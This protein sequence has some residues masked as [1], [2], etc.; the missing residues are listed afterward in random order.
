MAVN[1]DNPPIEASQDP[2]VHRVELIISNLL[3]IGV[4]SSLAIIVI[5]TV[6]SF[7][8]HPNYLKS[9]DD[10]HQLT[11]P[12]VAEFPHRLSAV[13]SGVAHSTGSRSSHL[14]CCC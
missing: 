13:V 11:T 7:V 1:V 10:F 4:T 9:R 12:S 2:R 6:I 8:R 3:H 5:G 14:A